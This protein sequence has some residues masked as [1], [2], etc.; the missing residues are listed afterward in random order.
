M[1][2]AQ[3]E[4][5]EANARAW[6][7]TFFFFPFR[8]H[9]PMIKSH[10]FYHDMT[11]GQENRL[12]NCSELEGGAPSMAISSTDAADCI[13]SCTICWVSHSLHH[14]EYAYHFINECNYRLERDNCISGQQNNEQMTMIAEFRMYANEVPLPSI[15]NVL[16]PTSNSIQLE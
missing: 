13:I 7:N 4:H 11:V 12:E 16:A 5:C 1:C 8:C 14:Y 2:I 6:G 15:D 10:I 9:L 3:L